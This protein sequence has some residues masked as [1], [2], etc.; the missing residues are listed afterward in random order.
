MSVT[1]LQV[2]RDTRLPLSGPQMSVLTCLAECADRFGRN[3]FPAQATIADRTRWSL[4]TVQRALAALESMGAIIRTGGVKS[5][6]GRRVVVWRVMLNALRDGTGRVFRARNPLSATWSYLGQSVLT[7][8]HRARETAYTKLAEDLGWPA[9][10]EMH[11]V[12]VEELIAAKLKTRHSGTETRQ[13][14]EVRAGE[15]A[16]GLALELLGMRRG[17]P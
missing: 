11:P 15:G 10:M 4:R 13:N 9:L 8:A 5:R 12:R 17:P 2:A 14:S 6:R 3:A 1:V 7:D 16:K